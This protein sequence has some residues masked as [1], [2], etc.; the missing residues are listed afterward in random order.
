MTA[1]HQR[2]TFV[3]SAD[4]APGDVP[5]EPVTQSTSDAISHPAPLFRFAVTSVA[6]VEAADVYEAQ[7][8]VGRAVIDAPVRSVVILE[9]EAPSGYT[10]PSLALHEHPAA[11]AFHHLNN[12]RMIMMGDMDLDEVERERVRYLLGEGTAQLGELHLAL[13]R[14]ERRL[15][16]LRNTRAFLDTDPSQHRAAHSGGK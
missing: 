2:R 6:I 15:T 3:G 4:A 16:E 1:I 13:I 7:E 11:L 8:I 10:A 14:T 5:T 12:A 9:V